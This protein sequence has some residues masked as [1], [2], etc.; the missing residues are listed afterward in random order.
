VNDAV[1]KKF[2]RAA[3]NAPASPAVQYGADLMNSQSA[4]ATFMNAPMLH[5]A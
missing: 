1:V 4:S 3:T 2:Q 5:A